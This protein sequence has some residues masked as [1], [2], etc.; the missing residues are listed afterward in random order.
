MPIYSVW[1]SHFPPEVAEEGR[2]ITEADL[3]RH[4]RN[5]RAILRTS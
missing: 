3:A 2:D 5:S 1:E 4:A